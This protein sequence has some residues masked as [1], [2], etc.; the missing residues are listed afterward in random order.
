L[1]PSVCAKIVQKLRTVHEDLL[2]SWVILILGSA[3]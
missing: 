3:G 2:I 1:A